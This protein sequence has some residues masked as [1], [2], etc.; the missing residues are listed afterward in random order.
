M[1]KGEICFAGMRNRTKERWKKIYR[2]SEGGEVVRDNLGDLQGR[3]KR[4]PREN[5]LDR[6]KEG[7]STA[8]GQ[9][10]SRECWRIT[11]E[12]SLAVRGRD[13]MG[14]G[15]VKNYKRS[16]VMK[17]GHRPPEGRHGAKCPGKTKR[18][19]FTLHMSYERIK[20]G[21]RQGEN[22]AHGGDKS[23][24]YIEAEQTRGGKERRK[25]GLL[26][27]VQRTTTFVNN[28]DRAR[29]LACNS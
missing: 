13:V 16:A 29:W 7:G 19:K 3:K 26:S 28:H 15:P 9:T 25:G 4:G 17:S 20:E 14:P 11:N 1:K 8:S 18:D 5:H 6:R 10:R 24:R 27:R 12:R 23:T 22:G 2:P 21:R